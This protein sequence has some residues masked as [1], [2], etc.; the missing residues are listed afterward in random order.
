MKLR[1]SN[2]LDEARIVKVEIYTAMACPFCK[3]AI[4]LLSAKNISFEEIDVTLSSAKRE[5]MR[6]RTNG[7]T[8]VPQVFINDNYIGGCEDLLRVDQA[9]DLDKLLSVL[10]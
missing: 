9:G 8:T 1:Q 3:R 5:A 6:N 7:R 2:A 10:S 4:K